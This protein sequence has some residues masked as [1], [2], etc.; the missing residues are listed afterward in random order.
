MENLKNIGESSVLKDM[1]TDSVLLGLG[2]FNYLI[3]DSSSPL[4]EH[5]KGNLID[6]T[7]IDAVANFL[8]FEKGSVDLAQEW[9]GDRWNPLP[10]FPKHGIMFFSSYMS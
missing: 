10:N 5:L 1:G 8:G 2:A 4:Q 3:L 7:D 9:D 6:S